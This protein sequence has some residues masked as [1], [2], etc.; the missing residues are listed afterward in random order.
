MHQMFKSYL[1]VSNTKSY[2]IAFDEFAFLVIFPKYPKETLKKCKNRKECLI[3][4]QLLFN[5]AIIS[6][7]KL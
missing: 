7:K 3:S 2:A 6:K 5:F 1:K 4:A